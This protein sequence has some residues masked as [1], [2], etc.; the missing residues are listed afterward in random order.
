MK[1]YQLLTAPRLTAACAAAMTLQLATAHP[2]RAQDAVAA[3]PEH[4]T[5]E[6]EN[7]QVRVLRVVYGPHEK[8]VMHEHPDSVAV[9]LTDGHLRIT[10]PDGRT[11]EPHVK[12]GLA[13][14]HPA[15]AHLIENLGSTPFE[16]VLTELKSPPAVVR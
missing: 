4:Y 7:D 2:A 9:Y 1:R 12:A 10:L 3:D 15:G 11:G 6:F 16:L 5:V 14:W 13:M 8:S